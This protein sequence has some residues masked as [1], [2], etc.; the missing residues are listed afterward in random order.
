MTE[1]RTAFGEDNHERR[2]CLVGD[3]RLL[4]AVFV[5]MLFLYVLWL[6]T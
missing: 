4:L 2:F 5:S 1:R 3:C 6:I